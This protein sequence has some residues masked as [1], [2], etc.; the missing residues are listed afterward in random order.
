MANIVNVDPLKKILKQYSKNLFWVFGSNKIINK[1]A[2]FQKTNILILMYHRVLPKS[3]IKNDYAYLTVELER[4]EKQIKNIS[5][6]YLPT[7]LKDFEKF[8]SHSSKRPRII[9]TFDDGYVDNMTYA[10]PIL[11]KYN[12]PATIYIS[13]SYPDGN[14][15]VWWYEIIDI[16]NDNQEICIIFDN[17]QYYFSLK[18]H[19]EKIDAGIKIIN[20]FLSMDHIAQSRLLNAIRNSDKSL[21]KYCKHKYRSYN[22]L[23]LN[24]DEVRILS[25]EPLITIG[26][27]AHN[28][29]NLSKLDRDVLIKEIS[30]SKCR[31]EKETGISIE[32]FAYPFGGDGFVGKREYEIVKQLGFKTSVTTYSYKLKTT[33][34]NFQLP[35]YAISR[36]FDERNLERGLHPK[37]WKN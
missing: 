24:W 9:I 37:F 35:R 21:T 20:M 1:I 36:F 12:V 16:V 5:Q 22:S 10:L 18:N 6:Y 19:Q 13:T 27:H 3:E 25:K 2:N 28:H 26:A 8:K 23:F 34:S 30:H 7:S 14:G 15:D 17:H 29:Y 11:K 33:T 32:H 4:F 31:L